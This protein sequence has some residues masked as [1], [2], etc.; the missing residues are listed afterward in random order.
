MRSL[1]FAFSYSVCWQCF[2]WF[3]PCKDIPALFETGY[4]NV[5]DWGIN[6]LVQPNICIFYMH[7]KK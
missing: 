1:V 4:S 7:A 2:R 5:S 3:R 6:C